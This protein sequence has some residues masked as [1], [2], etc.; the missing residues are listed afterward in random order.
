MSGSGKAS[1]SQTE[2]KPSIPTWEEL[3]ALLDEKVPLVWPKY[4]G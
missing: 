1:E 4:Y 2:A 3:E